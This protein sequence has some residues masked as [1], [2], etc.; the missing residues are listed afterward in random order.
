MSSSEH[1]FVRSFLRAHEA[2]LVH[3][4]TPMSTRHPAGFP[5]DL[6]VA[7]G[8]NGQRL[9]FATIQGNDRGPWQVGHPADAN[10]AGSVGLVVDVE[11]VGSVVAVDCTDSGSNDFGSL[12][13][14]PNAANCM[15]SINER[16][17]SN[18]W[19]VQNF[20]PLGIFVF[21]SA[22]VF[23]KRNGEQG[24]VEVGLPAILAAYPEDRIYSVANGSF[25]EYDRGAGRW[26]PTTYDQ[27]VSE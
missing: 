9:S 20:A 25:V 8:L 12:G 1:F 17:S 27:K 6:I 2:L 11:D 15:R 23:V 14:T 5:K 16:T 10:G 13:L 19:W 18:E 26:P 21:L 22:R 3:F 4:N 7:K 24:E